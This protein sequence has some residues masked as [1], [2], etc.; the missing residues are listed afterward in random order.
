MITP[1]IRPRLDPRAGDSVAVSDG[2]P[3]SGGCVVDGWGEGVVVAGAGASV[4]V[5]GGVTNST[6]F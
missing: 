1:I 4:G 2:V 6:N 5:A 3:V